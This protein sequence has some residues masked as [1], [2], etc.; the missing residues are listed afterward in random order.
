MTF[1]VISC[2]GGY[3]NETYDLGLSKVAGPGGP[4]VHGCLERRE[5]RGE[6]IEARSG[7]APSNNTLRYIFLKRGSGRDFSKPPTDMNNLFVRMTRPLSVP[8]LSSLGN[9]V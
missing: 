2:P 7:Y 5:K 9:D 1:K 3:I 4:P 6:Q 8:R